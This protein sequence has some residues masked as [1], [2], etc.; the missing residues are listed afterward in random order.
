[1]DSGFIWVPTSSADVPLSDTW[2]GR[3]EKTGVP[4]R[5]VEIRKVPWKCWDYDDAGGVYIIGLWRRGYW[6]G[7]GTQTGGHH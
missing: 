3:I 5:S 7:C 2:T 6:R 1:M 4:K